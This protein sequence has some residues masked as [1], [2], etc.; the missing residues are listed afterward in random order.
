[1]E[2]L[3]QVLKQLPVV[4]DPNLLV[5]IE[6]GDDAAV[7]R[8][9]DQASLIL[10]VDFFTPITDDPFEFGTISAA[11]S[12]SDIYAMGGKP[13]LALNVVGFPADLDKGILGKILQG[14]YAKA[15]DANCLIVGGHTVDDAE[16]KYG[17][18]VVGLVEPGKHVTNAGAQPGDSVVL[19]K[20]LGTGII[21]TGGKQG[22]SSTEVLQGA[23]ET[24]AALNRDASEA[25]I[26]VGVNSCTD[27]T[28]YGLLGHLKSMT[29]ASKVGAQINFGQVPVL[30]GT[31]DL[32][33]QDIVPGGTRRNLQNVTGSVEWHPDLTEHH[34]L[35]LADAQTSGGL[36]ISVPSAKLEQLLTKLKKAG[37]PVRSVIGEI[38][39]GPCGRIQ[40]SP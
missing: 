16:P 20:A 14:G 18:S 3:V 26:E 7:Y 9:N 25:M 21:T 38:V 5:G 35:L 11:N 39:E 8:L 17:L 19:T 28:G 13:L 30:P 36:L 24:M 37:V 34:Q 2:D 40:V 6:T 1:M 33:E 32:L 23:V 22:K 4:A 12:F 27:V 31:W 15:A 10:S 29:E